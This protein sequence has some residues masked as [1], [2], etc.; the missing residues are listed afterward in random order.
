MPRHILLIDNDPATT[1]FAT[2]TL[3]DAGFDIT[4]VRAGGDALKLLPKADDFDMLITDFQLSDCISGL[5]VAACWRDAV[6]GLPVLY[7]S[8]NAGALTGRLRINE[9][10]LHKPYTAGTLLRAV[11]EVLSASGAVSLQTQ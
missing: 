5:I 7:A 1:V 6:P 10:R 4:S 9:G 11:D 2:D 8:G 3:A